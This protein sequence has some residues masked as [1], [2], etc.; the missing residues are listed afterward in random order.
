M[1]FQLILVG[2]G[3]WQNWLITGFAPPQLNET[4]K[5]YLVIG[6]G[7]NGASLLTE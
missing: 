5:I 3:S 6:N 1:A 4:W 2:W 7:H